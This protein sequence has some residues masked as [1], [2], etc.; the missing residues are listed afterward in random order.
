MTDIA[1]AMLRVRLKS[2]RY[3]CSLRR[4]ALDKHDRAIR[5]V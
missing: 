3:I 1:L 5:L 2:L 4:I